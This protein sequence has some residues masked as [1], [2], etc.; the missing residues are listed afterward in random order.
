MTGS[1]ILS[2]PRPNHTPLKQRIVAVLTDG[3]RTVAFVAHHA[4]VTY[5]TARAALAEM[6][7]EGYFKVTA[8]DDGRLKIALAEPGDPV[9]DAEV[10]SSIFTA[11]RVARAR[12]VA[13]IADN[14]GLEP[15]RAFRLAVALTIRVA[16]HLEQET[17]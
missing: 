12:T 5:L 7:T 17:A 14:A 2:L 3:A 10:F 6:L 4:G 9:V 15:S 16:A 8:T 13:D 11:I 1:S